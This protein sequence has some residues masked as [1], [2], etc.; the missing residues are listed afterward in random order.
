MEL[1]LTPGFIHW[2]Y[3]PISREVLKPIRI[4][5]CLFERHRTPNVENTQPH[6]WRGSE[7]EIIK[8][9]AKANPPCHY[10]QG[11][12]RAGKNS[13]Y[14]LPKHLHHTMR[15]PLEE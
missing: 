8:T 14:I 7:L 15:V 2:R 12:Q 5:M 4:K 10:V 13:N 11:T 3:Y 1:L 9:A 6:S